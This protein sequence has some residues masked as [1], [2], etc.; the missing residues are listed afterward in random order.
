V[1]S[2]AESF[3]VYDLLKRA[4]TAE[5]PL[6]VANVVAN[7]SG[8]RLALGTKVLVFLDGRTEGSFG[9]KE[10]DEPVRR[11]AVALLAREK[12]RTIAYKTGPEEIVEVYIESIL[13]PPPL[14]IIGADPDAVPVV[15]FG[16]QLGFKVVLV[17]H[18]AGFANSARYPEADQIIVCQMEELAS[19]LKI[20]SQTFVLVKTH[21]YMRDKDILKFVLKSPAR[22]VGQLGPKARMD[23]LLTD[24]SKEGVGLSS[25]EEAKLYA[26]TGL[27]IGAESPEQIALSVLAEM[28]A[29]KNGR[30]GSFLREQS[31][32][33]HPRD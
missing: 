21:N 18:R 9:V 20:N 17:D 15:K 10:L 8:I 23:D 12:S 3:N 26:P 29:V 22:Y 24:L 14:V 25:A 32:A 13:P 19:S 31:A 16:K 2:S 28:L 33:I 11:D 4:I 7:N 5:T 1:R 27:D 6:A 30:L